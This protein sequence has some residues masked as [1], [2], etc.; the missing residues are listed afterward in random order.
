VG[1]TILIGFAEKILLKISPYYNKK[2]LYICTLVQH[3]CYYYWPRV[4]ASI[5][6][7]HKMISQLASLIHFFTFLLWTAVPQVES[8]HDVYLPGTGN[9]TLPGWHTFPYFLDPPI[10]H[11]SNQT[12]EENSLKRTY[13]L[14]EQTQR[15]YLMCPKGFVIDRIDSHFHVSPEKDNETLYQTWIKPTT[16]D[17][18]QQQQTVEHQ[19][20]CVSL[21]ECLLYQACVFNFGNEFCMRDPL[22]G[23]RKL[24]VANVTCTSVLIESVPELIR[25]RMDKVLHITYKSQLG[26][27]GIAPENIDLTATKLVLNERP[28]ARVFGVQCPTHPYDHGYS[29]KCRNLNLTAE[30]VVHRTWYIT[31]RIARPECQEK[32]VEVF[33]SIQYSPEDALCVPPGFLDQHTLQYSQELYPFRGPRPDHLWDT[34]ATLQNS[35]TKVQSFPN[36]IYVSGIIDFLGINVN[37]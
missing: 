8:F 35:Q 24:L 29:G 17:W 28:E 5:D 27:L 7:C 16:H 33:C 13:V 23:Q 26:Q 31:S 3:I 22:P 20:T 32:L 11:T 2:V 18:R 36:T 21:K 30:E 19:T 10:P 4:Q 34:L 15:A 37:A 1:T 6:W 12:K 14:N 25:H 9:T